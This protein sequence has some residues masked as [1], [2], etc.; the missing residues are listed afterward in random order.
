[1]SWWY[2]SF[3]NDTG[4]LGGCYV[5]TPTLA[6]SGDEMLLATRRAYQH[7]CNPG[8]E[9]KG[10]RLVRSIR[11]R[12]EYANRLLQRPEIDEDPTEP[13]RVS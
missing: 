7:K 2:L 5:E 10:V 6:D 12:P 11:I 8:G 3:A 4:W 9:V 1:M 13:A